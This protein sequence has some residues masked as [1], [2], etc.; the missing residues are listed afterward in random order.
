MSGDGQGTLDSVL[1]AIRIAGGEGVALQ[2]GNSAS[3]PRF[4][5][6]TGTGAIDGKLDPDD[7]SH[8]K[9]LRVLHALIQQW[10]DL[11]R[12]AAEDDVIFLPFDF[13]DQCT[14]WVRCK[15]G[16]ESVQLDVGWSVM[17]GWSFSP[18]HIS[19]RAHKVPSLRDSEWLFRHAGVIRTL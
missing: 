3:Y 6:R 13:S 14:G 19:E 16:G 18:S 1:Q 5:S 12:N 8:G 7:E 11:V 4:Y 15:F 10:L 17:E 9:T 2:S